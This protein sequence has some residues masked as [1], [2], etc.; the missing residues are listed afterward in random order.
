MPRKNTL[1]AED[2]KVTTKTLIFQSFWKVSPELPTNNSE[3][4]CSREIVENCKKIRISKAKIN[5]I[6]YRRINAAYIKA[7]HVSKIHCKHL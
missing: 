7:G 5:R 3:N 6:Y 4:C 1:L 2:W